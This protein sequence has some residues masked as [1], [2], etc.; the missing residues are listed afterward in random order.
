MMQKIELEHC[1]EWLLKAVTINEDVALID[2]EVVWKSGTWES[3]TWKGGTWES[4]TWMNGTWMNGTW[5]K[6]IWEDGTWQNGT[7]QNGTWKGGTWKIGAWKCGTWINGIWKDGTWYDGAWHNGIWESGTWKSGI[8][9]DGVWNGKEDRLLFMSA[10]L[11]VVFDI[12]GYATAYRTTMADGRGRWN[13][14]FTQ[15]EG[16]YYETD[17]PPAGYGTCVKGIHVSSAAIAWTYFPMDLDA[18]IQM[19]KVRFKK[20]DLLDCDGQ[21]IRI[22]G[23]IFT[24][25]KN[26]FLKGEK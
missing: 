6:G 15:P 2:G 14:K 18:Q 19:W 7:W 24:K 9:H 23:G 22:R 21:K 4:G 16:E 25:I 11:G 20:E 12:D 17:L 3:G 1:P 13:Y 5:M 26:P 8:W 10:L